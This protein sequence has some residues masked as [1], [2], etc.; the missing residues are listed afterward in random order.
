MSQIQLLLKSLWCHSGASHHFS[1]GFVQEA[2]LLV[3]PL[4]PNTAYSQQMNHQRYKFNYITPLLKTPF[5]FTKNTRPFIIYPIPFSS[6]ISFSTCSFLTTHWSHFIP[7][8]VTFLLLLAVSG[9]LFSPDIH[10][11]HSFTSFRPLFKR[12]ILSEASL[13]TYLKQPQDCF[14]V[15]HNTYYDIFNIYFFIILLC[16]SLH[17]DYKYS[18]R[19]ETYIAQQTF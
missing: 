14:L 9:T 3:S 5:H 7:A 4:T 16:F 6:L 8:T 13:T 1:P 11:V 2:S 18:I 12:H 17:L 19:P 10:M 15:L